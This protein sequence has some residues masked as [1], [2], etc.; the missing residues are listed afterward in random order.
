MAVQGTSET[1]MRKW[2]VKKSEISQ[3]GVIVSLTKAST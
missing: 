2:M 1:T 3:A